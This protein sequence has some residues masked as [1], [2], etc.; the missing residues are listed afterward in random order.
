MLST[1]FVVWLGQ[2][3]TAVAVP[4]VALAATHSPWT[5]GFVGGM[6]GLPLVTSPW[7]ARRAWHRLVSGRAIGLVLAGQVLGL[8]VVPLT[9]LTGPVQWYALAATGLV[10]GTC[11]A[12]AGPAQSSLLAEIAEPLGAY[13]AARSLAWQDFAHRV[14]MI[15]APALGA[16][17]VTAWGPV[18]LL[19]CEAAGMAVGAVLV[20]TVRGRARVRPVADT[21]TERGG[22]T[23]RATLRRHPSVAVAVAI[24]GVGGLVWFAFT[25]GLAVR[26]AETHQPGALIAAGMT[27]YGVTSVL[28]ALVC[29]RVLPRLPWLAT[30]ATAYVVLGLTFAGL[31]VCG[32]SV[33]L[34]AAVAAVGGCLTPFGNAALAA[35]ITARTAGAARR[36]AFAASA[37]VHDGAVSV[38]L[39]G[40]GAV[41]GLAGSTATLVTAGA[42]QVA[43]GLAGLA[44]RAHRHGSRRRVAA[45]ARTVP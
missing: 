17:A 34:V 25:L 20:A 19:W 4:L 13:A 36:T 8:L 6:A 26:G 10:S 27:G 31:A 32:P 39:V 9:A 7:W 45:L 44:W 38:G 30:A 23:M 33:P 43:A 37:F 1:T 29:P 22:P 21:G 40:G 12:L 24:D 11:G 5:T 14:S 42:I 16:V 35:L 3:M 2:R 41:I 28:A 15:V 18:P